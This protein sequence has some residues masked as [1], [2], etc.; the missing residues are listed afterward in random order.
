MSKS[1]AKFGFS[2]TDILVN[3]KAIVGDEMA[4][5]ALPH[6]ISWPALPKTMLRG[7]LARTRNEGGT[8]IVR[9]EDGPSAVEIQYQELEIIERI[10]VFYG[11]LAIT[12]L[13]VIQGSSGFKTPARPVK[14]KV[15]TDEQKHHLDIVRQSV[16]S[17]LLSDALC[18]LGAHIYSKP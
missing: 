4:A 14:K 17:E 5:R 7:K 16:K 1:F 2:A 18:R 12:R 9:A 15:L 6:R 3:W 11:Y 8:L 13:K 10:N